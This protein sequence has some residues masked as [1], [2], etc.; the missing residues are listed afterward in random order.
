MTTVV[1]NKCNWT[2]FA[3]S[4]EYAEDEVKRFNEYFDTLSPEVQQQCYGGK[5][6]SLSNYRCLVCCGTDFTP[7]Y[8]ARDGSTLNPVIYEPKE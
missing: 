3:V 2:S 8:T 4:R 1:C 6:S 5:G 7:G